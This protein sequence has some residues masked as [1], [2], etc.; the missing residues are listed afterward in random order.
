MSFDMVCH[1][2]IPRVFCVFEK[3]KLVSGL[4]DHNQAAFGSTHEFNNTRME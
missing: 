2:V 1:S 4:L 3:T